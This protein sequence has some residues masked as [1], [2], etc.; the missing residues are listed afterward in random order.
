MG[1]LKPPHSKTLHTNTIC[2]SSFIFL[3][4]IT[5]TWLSDTQQSASLAANLDILINLVGDGR[6]RGLPV[7]LAALLEVVL[8]AALPV[9]ADLGRLGRGGEEGQHERAVP[10]PAGEVDRHDDEPGCPA[11]A[12]QRA[13]ADGARAMTAA[14]AAPTA[15]RA[16]TEAAGS[17]SA[18]PRRPRRESKA[19]AIGGW[20]EFVVGAPD[21]GRPGCDC[22]SS[23][24]SDD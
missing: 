3:S 8:D 18:A 15:V 4:R 1:L 24:P 11:G 21:S 6:F 10:V 16:A 23:S 5:T 22:T 17:P 14:S 12:V 9:R 19:P 13:A 7:A 20:I 2:G